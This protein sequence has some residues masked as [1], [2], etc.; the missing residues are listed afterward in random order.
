MRFDR[1]DYYRMAEI[2]I[3]GSDDRVELL[4]GEIYQ[5]SP[6]GSPHGACLMML[7]ELF[8]A[9]L[10]SRASCRVQLPIGAG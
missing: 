8:I 6:I 2:G 5:M 10:G 7:T 1:A 3:I 9:N 4:E